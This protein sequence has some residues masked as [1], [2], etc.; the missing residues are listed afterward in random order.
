MRT[1]PALLLV[2]AVLS[3]CAGGPAETRS[4]SEPAEPAG[5]T[6]SADPIASAPE[7]RAPVAPTLPSDPGYRSR[8]G[9]YADFVL[10]E[11][12]VPHGSPEH[13]QFLASCIESAGFKVEVVDGSIS[14][15]PPPEQAAHYDDAQSQCEEAAIS[16]GLVSEIDDPSDEELA[17]WYEARLLTHQCLVE[18]GY[19]ISP[20]PSEDSYVEAGGRNWHPYDAILLDTTAVEAECPQDLVVLFERLASGSES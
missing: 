14:A 6:G 7:A 15:R 19:P 11:A 3:A 9:T 4:Q 10:G 17:A 1:L 5:L 8:L 20:P 2:G 12:L 13:L 18:K 16:S